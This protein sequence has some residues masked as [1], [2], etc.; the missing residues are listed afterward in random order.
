MDRVWRRFTGELAPNMNKLR[1]LDSQTGDL[2][3][4]LLLFF[5]FG[6]VT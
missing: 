1:H 5:C 6:F 4:A 2:G 3:L